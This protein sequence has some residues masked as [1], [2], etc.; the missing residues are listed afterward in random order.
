METYVNENQFYL[1]D[2]E[3]DNATFLTNNTIMYEGKKYKILSGLI[4]GV[5]VAE[6]LN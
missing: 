5:I 6:L 1:S 2:N 4:H 3:L